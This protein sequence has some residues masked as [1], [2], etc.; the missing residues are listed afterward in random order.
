MSKLIKQNFLINFLPLSEFNIEKQFFIHSVVALGAK[1][2]KSIL[3]NCSK[4]WTI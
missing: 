2:V 1:S 3:S 4:V